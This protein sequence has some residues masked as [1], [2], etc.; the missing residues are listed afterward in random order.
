MKKFQI[1][2][3]LCFAFV[4]FNQGPAGA[5]PET[6]IMPAPAAIAENVG[7][8]P[9]RDLI[10]ENS[11]ADVERDP[12]AGNSEPAAGPGNIAENSELSSA[13]ALSGGP[14]PASPIPAMFPIDPDEEPVIY[15]TQ[16]VRGSWNI[17]ED[18]S[19]SAPVIGNIQDGQCAE[20]IYKYY[21]WTLI[22][23]EG[24]KGWISSKA[25]EY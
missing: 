25:L 9:G 7:A 13:P 18:T 20:V 6:A 24:M 1:L 23:F 12:I 8:V 2:S 16:C 15:P 14:W 5:S 19:L 3:V 17:R 22:R 11:E 10:A 4:V 21:G